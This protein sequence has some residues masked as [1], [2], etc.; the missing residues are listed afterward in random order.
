MKLISVAKKT[1][2]PTMPKRSSFLLLQGKPPETPCSP[3]QV[4]ELDACFLQDRGTYGSSFSIQQL[5]GCSKNASVNNRAGGG[6][7]F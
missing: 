1:Q 3:A 5:F 2:Q 6:S 7:S 4:P